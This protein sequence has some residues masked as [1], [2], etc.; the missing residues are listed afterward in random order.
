M[1]I[2][3][4]YITSKMF[5]ETLFLMGLATASGAVISVII[6]IVAFLILL[7]KAKV[8]AKENL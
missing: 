1:R 7:R 3:G 5:P 8:P 6:C 4:V 2:P